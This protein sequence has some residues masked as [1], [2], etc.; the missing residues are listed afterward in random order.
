MIFWKFFSCIKI[1]KANLQNY[2]P[3]DLEVLP[4]FVKSQI[5][6]HVTRYGNHGFAQK[7]W[8]LKALL[9][10]DLLHLDL[11]YCAVTSDIMT[12]LVTSSPN[13]QELIIKDAS[14]TLTSSCK[15]S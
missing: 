1:I 12:Q 13:L 4:R 8:T 11:Q 2:D 6:L 9:H 3:N 14:P 10:K 7:L 15:Y 5:I